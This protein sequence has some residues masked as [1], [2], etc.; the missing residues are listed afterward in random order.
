MKT[1]ITEDRVIIWLSA[2]DTYEWAT[3]PKY[4]W[5]C[6]V[7]LDRKLRAEYDSNGL[8]DLT[9]DS[10]R[11]LVIDGNELNAIVADYLKKKLKPDHPL[12]YVI[13]GQFEERKP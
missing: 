9:V 2:N 7:L 6:S 4:G 11:D 13:I 3:H 12:Y 10:R 8:C 1:R 5:P